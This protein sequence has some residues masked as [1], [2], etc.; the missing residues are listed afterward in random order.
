M[1]IVAMATEKFFYFNFLIHYFIILK[2]K[3]WNVHLSEFENWA[4]S[5][6]VFSFL[7]MHTRIK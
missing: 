1:I 4:I 2:K 6:N 5:F 3:Y 7:K